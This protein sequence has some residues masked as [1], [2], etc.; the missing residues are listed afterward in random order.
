MNKLILYLNTLSNLSFSQISFLVYN[1]VIK[2]YLNL[3][4][5]DKRRINQEIRSEFNTI[6]KRI[7]EILGEEETWQLGVSEPKNHSEYYN[8][9]KQNIIIFSKNGNIANFIDLWIIKS[10][11][12]ELNYNYQRFYL[13]KEVFDE[14]ELSD[15]KRTVLIQKW[16]ETNKQNKYAWMGFNCAVRLI[17]WM[18]I[19]KDIDVN[20]IQ[21][22]QWEVIEN[23]IYQQFLFNSKNIEHH[24]PGNHVLFQYYSEW[25]VSNIF[26][27]WYSQQNQKE[28]I[29]KRL[30]KEFEDEYLDDGL[31]FELSTHYHLQITLLGLSLISQLQN[32]GVVVPKIFLAI[33]NKAT[34]VLN[35][36]QIGDYYPAIGDGCYN[37]FHKSK[38]KDL[39]NV[40]YLKNKYLQLHDELES[41]ILIDNNFQ[42][43][44]NNLFKIIFDV[45][46][47][48]LHNNPGHGHADL[49]SIILGYNK[50][51]IFIDPGT[52]QY[53]NSEE[54][55]KLKRTIFH[56]TVSVDGEDQA[57]LWGF[58][59]WA[60]LPQ[61]IKSS[62]NTVSK[63]VTVLEGQF[64]GYR[65]LGGITHKR[66]IKMESNKVIVKDNLHGNLG[67]KIQVDFILHPEIMVEH[68]KSIIFLKSKLNDFELKCKNQ[69]MLLSIENIFIYD[70]YNVATASKKIVFTF[71]N[72]EYNFDSEII[73][74]VLN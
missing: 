3:L 45:G 17:N 12:I 57:K 8:E 31:H 18:K 40:D 47:I 33:M 20:K 7:N 4:S 63:S 22:K 11:D 64:Y 25:L 32:L 51:P 27:K 16:I 70:S 30:L 28:I 74:K 6:N 1:K 37:F 10:E 19:L 67:T 5:I 38:Y 53:K 26:I 9:L 29:L 59:R 71:N 68:E 50:L 73:F 52:F 55:L 23:S 58:F 65:H 61:K 21:V 2:K 39:Q 69:N 44:D 72:K 36:F 41:Q 54:S 60:Y 56:N 66:N 42:I 34:M 48:G 49:L 43:F 13:F 62:Y 24:I 46:N 35:K 15:E 14:I